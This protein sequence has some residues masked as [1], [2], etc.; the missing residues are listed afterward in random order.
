M[1]IATASDVES[2]YRASVA[3]LRLL[4]A[5]EGR[6]LR[7]GAVADQNWK[8][9]GGELEPRDRLD[10]LVRDGAALHPPAFSPR[11]VFELPGLT[12]DEPTGSDWPM[13]PAALSAELFREAG[14]AAIAGAPVSSDDVLA[15][16]AASWRVPVGSASPAL[17]ESVRRIGAADRIVV[18]GVTAIHALAAAAAQRRDLNLADQVLCI[19]AT[20][21]ER[22][23]FG[24]ALLV[25]GGRARRAAIVT[26][27]EHISAD[28]AA[29]GFSR[30][31]RVLVAEDAGSS[32]RDAI[33]RLARA[34]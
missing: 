7:F 9:L 31:D 6:G 28:A 13:A 34:T 20:R 8:A 33:D 15:A 21:S 16:A 27:G 18:A 17:A 14:R 10:W 2:F 23:L 19:A 32:L 1:T 12:D 24:L 25:A 3:G 11:I 4:D 22:H 26:P 30:F 5:R 29:L